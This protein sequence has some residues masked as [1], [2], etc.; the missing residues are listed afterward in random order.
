MTR[1]YIKNGL[2]PNA[3]STFYLNN[4]LFTSIEFATVTKRIVDD[5]FAKVLKE[6]LPELDVCLDAHQIIDDFKKRLECLINGINERRD[7]LASFIEKKY[8]ADIE[9]I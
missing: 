8:G 3:S 4:L 2:S 7:N 1:E 6:T 9:V 5:I